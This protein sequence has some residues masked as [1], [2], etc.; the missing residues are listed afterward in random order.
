MVSGS[1]KRTERSPEKRSLL[2]HGISYTSDRIIIDKNVT[3]TEIIGFS[4]MDVTTD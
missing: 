2:V 1:I 3:M 4:I